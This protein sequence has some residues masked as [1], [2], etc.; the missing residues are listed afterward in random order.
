M[1]K[2]AAETGNLNAQFQLGYCYSHGIGTEVNNERAFESYKI[3]A[4]RGHNI[5]QYNLALLYENVKKDLNEAFYWYNKAIENG[6][7]DAKYQLGYL[8]LNGIGVEI[9]KERAFELFKEAAEKGHNDSQYILAT[10]YQLNNNKLCLVLLKK[11]AMK[12]NV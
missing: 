12:S 4:K 7:L 9:N 1:Y 2:E 5:A 8:Y 10:L 6:N 11:A 3:A